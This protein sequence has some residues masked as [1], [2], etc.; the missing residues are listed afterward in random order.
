M[1][2]LLRLAPGIGGRKRG[3]GEDM[4]AAYLEQ[5]LSLDNLVDC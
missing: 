1:P 3:A 5:V 2:L 4:T